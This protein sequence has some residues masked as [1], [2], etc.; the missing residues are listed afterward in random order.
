MR[1]RKNKA[2]KIMGII[3]GITGAIIVIHIVPI[4]VW[5]IALAI[6]ICMFLLIALKG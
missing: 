3:S 2:I 5:Y 4:Y 6:T 1:R